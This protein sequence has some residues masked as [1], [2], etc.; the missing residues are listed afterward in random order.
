MVL[1]IGAKGLRHV[2]SDENEDATHGQYDDARKDTFWRFPDKG[3]RKK[4]RADQ[5]QKSKDDG[6]PIVIHYLPMAE[7]N[8]SEWQTKS[9]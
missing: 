9:K 2:A 8:Q 6:H 7:A 3:L 1:E 4:R 5:T